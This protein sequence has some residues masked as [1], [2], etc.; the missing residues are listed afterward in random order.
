MKVKELKAALADVDDEMVV[1]L[2]VADPE[3][4]QMMC[5]PSLAVADAGCGDV[6]AFI[7]DGT[8]GECKHG[9][10]ST[11]CRACVGEFEHFHPRSHVCPQCR[12]VW[13]CGDSCGNPM[14]WKCRNCQPSVVDI[15]TA[16]DSKHQF[17]L[18]EK[19]GALYIRVNKTYFPHFAPDRLIDAWSQGLLERFPD[20]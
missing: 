17:N 4:A 13:Q 1:L 15:S 9:R 8:D 11:Q 14:R 19:T 7:I 12:S 16:S 18:S 6:E 20:A 3:A 5:S 10:D 2:R